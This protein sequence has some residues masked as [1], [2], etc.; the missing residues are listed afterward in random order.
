MQ[1]IILPLSDYNCKDTSQKY[2]YICCKET[3]IVLYCA[4]IKTIHIILSLS[5]NGRRSKKKR[6]DMMDVDDDE[7]KD[8]DDS[9][10]DDNNA[11]IDEFQISI[12]Q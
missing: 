6:K 5:G 12:P 7:H 9:N 2:F 10:E 1:S 3:F 8:M 11:N 4:S